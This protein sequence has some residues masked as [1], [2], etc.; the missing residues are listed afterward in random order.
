MRLTL[1][2]AVLTLSACGEVYDTTTGLGACMAYVD[3]YNVCVSQMG[4]PGGFGGFEDLTETFCEQHDEAFEGF[5]PKVTENAIEAF[6]CSREAIESIDCSDPLDFPNVF[7][8]MEDCG[9]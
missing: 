6:N 5:Q 9:L 3:A 7:T 2:A 4:T 8:S 1:F